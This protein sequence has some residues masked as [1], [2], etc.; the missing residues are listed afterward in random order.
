MS[1]LVRALAALSLVALLLA[2]GAS[3]VQAPPLPSGS[4]SVT[5][6][7]IPGAC[8]NGEPEAGY[9]F[10]KKINVWVSN[11]NCVARWGNLETLQSQRVAPGD[12]VTMVAVPADGSNSATYAPETKTIT[13]RFP[14]KRVRG[15]GAADLTCSSIPFPKKSATTQWQWAQFQVSMPR[16][17]FVDNPGS[18]CAGQ[19]LCGGVTTNAW[20]WAGTPP[21]H[22]KKK[23]GDPDADNKCGEDRVV[24][25]GTLRLANHNATGPLKVVLV[26]YR[27][28][29]KVIVQRVTTDNTGHYQ[30]K[31]GAGKYYVAPSDGMCRVGVAKCTDFEDVRVRETYSSLTIYRTIDFES[32]VAHSRQP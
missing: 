9:Y 8:T 31:T 19:H 13:W 28:T 24:I 26:E 27:G 6:G 4:A 11:P 14:G 29:R 3:A 2:A 1:H 5:A 18:N 16:T 30:I 10:A 7:H 32:E 21:A 25:S 17:F 15:C 23:T 20:G 12:T 22:C